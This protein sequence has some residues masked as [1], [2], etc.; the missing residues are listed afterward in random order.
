MIK[1]IDLS[2]IFYTKIGFDISNLLE[3]CHVI[4]LIYIFNMFCIEIN[5]IFGS[6]SEYFES[7]LMLNLKIIE[8]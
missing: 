5:M 4:Y 7:F 3:Y 8:L 6:I 2:A 1:L